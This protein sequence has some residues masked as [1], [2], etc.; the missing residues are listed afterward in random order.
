M[1]RQARTRSGVRARAKQAQRERGA[2]VTP[3]AATDAAQRAASTAAHEAVPTA[4]RAGQQEAQQQAPERDAAWRSPGGAHLTAARSSHAY[5]ARRSH[6]VRLGARGAAAAGSAPHARR[7][8]SRQRS[9]RCHAAACG[10]A[11]RG[12]R[13]RHGVR[14]RIRRRGARGRGGGASRLTH[15]LTIAAAAER[16]LT[17]AALSAT[18]VPLDAPV[19]VSS[20]TFYDY[21]TLAGPLLL[22]G[23]FYAVREKVSV[24]GGPGAYRAA[25]ARSTAHP[26]RR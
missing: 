23:V 26:G 21:A 12:A 11:P 2:R 9:C 17:C 8:R 20:F 19:D 3:V 15:L 10:P 13:C 4:Q 16:L 22:Y 24:R 25:P 6:A 14:L 1:M 5:V 18:Q 7:A